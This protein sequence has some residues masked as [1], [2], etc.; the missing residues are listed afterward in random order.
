MDISMK[1]DGIEDT[2]LGADR[3]VTLDNKD[4]VS[5]EGVKVVWTGCTLGQVMAEALKSV[6]IKR[7]GNL[8]K[9]TTTQAEAIIKDWKAKG[10]RMDQLAVKG[11]VTAKVVEVVRE[12]TDEEL[13][14]MLLEDTA[15]FERVSAMHK[16]RMEGLA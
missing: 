14:K 8:R 1:L 3:K 2:I 15:L 13:E 9:L 5:L 4:V 10:I 12:P 16:K 6:V 7:Q 11:P